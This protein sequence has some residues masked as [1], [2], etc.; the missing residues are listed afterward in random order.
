MPFES[1]VWLRVIMVTYLVREVKPW[2]G[3]RSNKGKLG[4]VRQLWRVR[5][6]VRLRR[7]DQS[8]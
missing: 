7:D 6:A 4:R 5:Q 8:G 3:R 1:R 2:S